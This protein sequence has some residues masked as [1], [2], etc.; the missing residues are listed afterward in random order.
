MLKLLF[1]G[2]LLLAVIQC[3]ASDGGSVIPLPTSRELGDACYA[4]GLPSS[5]NPFTGAS[6][7]MASCWLHGWLEASGAEHSSGVLPG[8]HPLNKW[9]PDN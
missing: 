5:A 7:E 2:T 8:G 4:A 3:I 6:E 1:S 9:R